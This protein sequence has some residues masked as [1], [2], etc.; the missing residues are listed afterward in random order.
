M[1][2]KDQICFAFYCT[3]MCEKPKLTT[4]SYYKK[5]QISTCKSEGKTSPLPGLRCSEDLPTLPM[6]P[7][8]PK[9][10]G[11]IGSKFDP[12]APVMGSRVERD[13]GPIPEL[14][15]EGLPGLGEA[16]A[17]VMLLYKQ[18]LSCSCIPI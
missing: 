2:K 16:S 7:T 15:F 13:I 4:F 1:D 18:I 8:P 9:P 11:P 5:D 3:K 6:V 12:T 10:N 14:R 17:A